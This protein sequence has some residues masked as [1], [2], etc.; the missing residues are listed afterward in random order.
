M[1]SPTTQYLAHKW[2]GKQFPNGAAGQLSSLSRH[3]FGFSPHAK[4]VRDD[5]FIGTI[6]WRDASYLCCNNTQDL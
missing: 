2:V 6:P 4:G 3:K 1:A 5:L